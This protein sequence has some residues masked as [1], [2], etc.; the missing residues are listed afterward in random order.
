[1]EIFSVYPLTDTSK[2]YLSNKMSFKLKNHENKLNLK[3]P[4]LLLK[5][6]H[7]LKVC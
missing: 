5:I 3:L 7:L 6:F 1:M 2:L 4:S